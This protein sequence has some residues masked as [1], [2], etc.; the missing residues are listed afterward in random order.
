[1][2]YRHSYHA[3][4]FADVLK[5]VILALIVR[6][7]VKKDMPFRYLDTHAGL[8]A[9]DLEADE[10]SRTGEW[11]DGV[12]RL[13]GAELEPEI[14]ALLAPW[15]AAVEALNPDGG[16]R[17]Y[18]GSP[19]IVRAQARP[20][21]RMTLCELHPEDAANLRRR[22]RRD[23]RVSAVEIDGYTALNAYVPPKERRGVVLVDPPFEEA[24]E[25]RRMANGLKR[26]HAKW[27]TGTYVLWY[28]IKEVRETDA[29]VQS[30]GKAGIPSVIAAELLIHRPNET[31]R[32]NGCGLV[33]VN[34]PWTLARDLSPLLPVL[35]ELL[36]RDAGARGRVL[37][38]APEAQTASGR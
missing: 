18:P 26:A 4:N 12:G 19:E 10:A 9:Y 28:P 7:L 31:A 25:F 36:G 27:P 22:Y 8:G 15:R 34:P 21:D 20:G 24:G 37:T 32:L 17:F 33:I 11:R 38:V 23:E 14:A 35:A 16:L 1:M 5:H 30:I 3:G 29:F 13:W 2:N 6:H